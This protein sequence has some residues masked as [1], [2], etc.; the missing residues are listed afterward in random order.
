MGRVTQQRKRHPAGSSAPGAAHRDVWGCSVTQ[1]LL[2]AG[3]ATTSVPR[4]LGAAGRHSRLSA[5]R[6]HKGWAGCRTSSVTANVATSGKSQHQEDWH[7]KEEPCSDLWVAGR[8]QG[9]A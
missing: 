2:Q 4:A 3:A 5:A 1:S 9:R 8:Y 6:A 7:R